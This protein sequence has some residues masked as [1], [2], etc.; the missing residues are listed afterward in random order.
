MEKH[1]YTIDSSNLDKEMKIVSYGH[2]GVPF[3]AF[4][5][6]CAPCTNYE[7]FGAVR[8]LSHFIENGKMQLFCVDTVDNESWYCADG[9]NTWR[10]ARQESYYK[11]LVD[12]VIPFMQEKIQPKKHPVVMGVD[13]GATHAAIVYFRRPELFSGLVALSG[14]Y[15][16]SYYYHGWMDSTLYDNSVECFLNNMP[17]DHPWIRKYNNNPMVFCCGRGAWEDECLRTLGN[18]AR[19]MRKKRISAVTSYWGDDVS[20]DWHWWRHQLEYYIPSLL[21]HHAFINQT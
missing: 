16:S 15:D 20:H 17:E 9:I 14:I 10:S 18:L 6:Q 5:T 21:D 3:L 11:Y 19:I 13:M 8:T 7:D 2:G 1:E 12:E 4:P